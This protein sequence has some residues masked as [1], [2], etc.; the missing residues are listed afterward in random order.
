MGELGY[1]RSE[2]LYDLK[3]WEI[4]A[5]LDGYSKRERTYLLMTRWS[6]FMIM[7]T[8]MA[9]LRKAGLHHPEDLL[10]FSWERA[11]HLKNLP[12]PEEFEEMKRILNQGK[13]KGDG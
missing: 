4:L 3:W 5:I 6:T 9:D 8:G 10:T 11:E 12:T 7:S 13:M 2:F 1:N